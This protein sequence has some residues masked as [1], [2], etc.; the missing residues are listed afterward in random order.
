MMAVTM[1]FQMILVLTICL[2]QIASD[3]SEQ[4][5]KNLHSY[6]SEGRLGKNIL[7]KMVTSKVL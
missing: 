7:T 6:G 4:N 3:D 1:A 2:T 5:A